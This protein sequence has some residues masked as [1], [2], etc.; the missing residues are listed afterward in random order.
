MR[1]TEHFNIHLRPLG[2]PKTYGPKVRTHDKSTVK[3][4][5]TAL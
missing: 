5:Y 1:I 4:N 2:S 3:E